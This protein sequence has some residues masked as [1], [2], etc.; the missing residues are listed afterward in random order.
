MVL[1]RHVI[2]PVDGLEED[3][4]VD[5]VEQRVEQVPVMTEPVTATSNRLRLGAFDRKVQVGGDVLDDFIPR[6]IGVDDQS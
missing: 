2:E 4:T 6:A 3:E 5:D 1:L